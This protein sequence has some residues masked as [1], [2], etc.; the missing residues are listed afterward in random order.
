MGYGQL[1]PWMSA[2]YSLTTSI[3]LNFDLSKE[4]IDYDEEY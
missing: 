4:R 2:S 1:C 3:A